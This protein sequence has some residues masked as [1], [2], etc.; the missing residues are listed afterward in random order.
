M[1]DTLIIG[2]A[3]TVAILIGA[4]LYFGGSDVR[5]LF[6]STGTVPFTVLDTGTYSG[7]VTERK[8]YL[9]HSQEE[10]NE[11]WLLVHDT[12]A[13]TSVDFSKSEVIAVFD[14]TH[15]TGGYD[16]SVDSVVDKS[17]SSRIVS[18][19]RVE[20]GPSCVSSA[21]VSSPFQIIVVPKSDAPLIREE[22]TVIRECE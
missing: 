13:P 5:T 3:F 1:R 14:G 19:T 12:S 17:S 2:I 7:S 10:L 9:I 15:A 20:P 11:L 8:N 16:V 21:G 22:R 18:I 4:W 6:N